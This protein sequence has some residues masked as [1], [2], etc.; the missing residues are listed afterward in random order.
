MVEHYQ[1]PI[2]VSSKVRIRQ[3]LERR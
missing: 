3:W 2:Y 1:L